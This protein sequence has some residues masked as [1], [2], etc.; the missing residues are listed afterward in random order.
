MRNTIPFYI[1]FLV[2]KVLLFKIS[3]H[4]FYLLLFYISFYISRHHFSQIFRTSFSIIWKQDFCHKF[5]FF[6]GFSQSPPPLNGQIPRRVIKVFCWSSL[7]GKDAFDI[8]SWSCPSFILSSL[9]LI[10]YVWI[11]I[12]RSS[13]KFCEIAAFVFT[14]VNTISFSF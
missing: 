4:I 3:H 12:F 13:E 1:L 7:T 11:I 6:N 8:S 9:F 2:L 10:W 14:G 5:S